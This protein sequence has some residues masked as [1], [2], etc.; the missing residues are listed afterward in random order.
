MCHALHALKLRNFCACE[1]LSKCRKFQV[2]SYIWLIWCEIIS[3]VKIGSQCVFLPVLR[4]NIFQFLFGFGFGF[5][6]F[7]IYALFYFIFFRHLSD[8]FKALKI[9][10]RHSNPRTIWLLYLILYACFPKLINI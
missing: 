3:I 5:G 2:L 9:P 6:T 10:S 8:L 1:D 7:L 4:I